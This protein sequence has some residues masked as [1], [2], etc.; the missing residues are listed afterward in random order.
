MNFART[1]IQPPRPRATF[2][3]RGSVQARLTEALLNRRVLLMC[4]PAGYGKTTLLAHCVAQLP[5]GTAVAWISADPGDDLLRLVE[6]LVAALEPF[7][8]PWRTAPEA[9][10]VRAGRASSDERQTLIAEIVNTLDACD[11]PHGV[12]VFDDVHRVDDP[13]FFD[14]IDRLA[15]RLGARWTLALTSRTEPPIALARLRASAELA[16]FRQL[17]LQF[18]RDET[19]Q[20][21]RDAGLDPS[22][23]DRLFDRTQGWP[24]GLRI[25]IGALA[26]DGAAGARPP[27]ASTGTMRAAD[28]P[29]FDF[30][31]TE[32]LDQ[33]HSGLR[34]FL[35]RTSV[36]IDLEPVRCAQVAGI[37]DAAPLLDEIERLGL[38][39]SVVDDSAGTLRLHDLFRDALSSR[40]RVERPDVWRDCLQRA[41]A[42]ENDPTRRQS[43]LLAAGR[44]VEAARALLDAAPGL[45][46]G[47]AATTVLRLC[48]AF[49]PAFV[50]KSPQLQ[51]A[52]GLT[53]Q[54]LWQL[55]DA[56]R[57]YAQAQQ[58]YGAM[59]DS[60]AAQVLAARRAAILAP[61]GRLDECSRLLATLQPSTDTEAQ[62]VAATAHLWLT[63]ERN[64]FH[65]VAARFGTLLQLQLTTTRLEDWQTIPPPRVT[66]CPGAA[67]LVTRWARAALQVTG[68]RPVPLRAMAFIALGWTALWQ[69]DL[70]AARES[71]TQ[72]EAEAHWIG[73]H[74]IARSH[75]L[76]LR[77]VL[78][79]AQGDHAAAMQAMSTRVAEQ[80]ASY[81]DWGLW[82]A[83][84]V[85]VRVAAA[86][87][88][89]VTART[90]L[91]QM[92]A[93][94]PS[95]PETSARR[96]HPARGPQGVLAWLEGRR[97]DAIAHWQAALDDEEA[98]D[99]MGQASELRVRLAAA[100]VERG[101]LDE[102]AASIEPWLRRT[103]EGPRGAVF[104]AR[105]LAQLARADWRGRLTPAAQATLASR[106]AALVPTA[107][108][109]AM[110]PTRT[111]RAPD[112]ALAA[113]RLTAREL[114]VLARI[115]AGDSNKVIARAFDLSPHTVKRHV[116]N[117]L[118]K[119]G[120]ETRGQAAAAYHQQHA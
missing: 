13:A 83:L 44:D 100:H 89:A 2:V 90:W 88:D 20:L 62:T 18:A 23:A 85:A 45:N 111:D 104:A 40:L 120:V 43:L 4:A 15:E 22:V 57:H 91:A 31:V 30:L 32:V 66:A 87:E 82:H 78:A 69:A 79:L 106:V 35:L 68:D 81:G 73:E 12:I 55:H 27:A 9:L 25:A 51:R 103:E 14:F 113:E 70:D 34:D 48:S 38:F 24:A 98:A 108:L 77:A 59:G 7:D 36:L 6:C 17:H 97:D 84:F 53:K 72:A 107:G 93:L 58:L 41:A 52:L 49:P 117:I 3:E 110:A 65:H 56:E 105:A 116:A 64:E 1:K 86:C 99:L 39:T 11:V 50:A 29:L 60:D 42:C 96:L 115:A 101:A 54:T 16:E 80:P 5:N 112:T 102:A 46:L 37:D 8:P 33:L 94:A 76:A 21:A 75:G 119:L 118:G 61:L 28:R 26:R 47:G 67:P 63:L 74:V 71:L 10:A 109:A 92:L 114:E 95:L 19:R